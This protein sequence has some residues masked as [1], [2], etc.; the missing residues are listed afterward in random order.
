MEWVQTQVPGGQVKYYIDRGNETE[1][2]KALAEMIEQQPG[3]TIPTQWLETAA[4]LK[5][6][7][8]LKMVFSRKVHTVAPAKPVAVEPMPV[9][10]LSAQVLPAKVAAQEKPEKSAVFQE[11]V[12]VIRREIQASAEK[13]VIRLNTLDSTLRQTLT[14]VSHSDSFSC[15]E[16]FPCLMVRHGKLLQTA[17]EDASDEVQTLLRLADCRFQ[18]EAIQQKLAV[19]IRQ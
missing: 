8:L 18:I 17:G 13:L 16:C 11:R 3:T 12:L 2:M 5:M 10:I 9:Q 4:S 6:N 15:G 19:L 14:N 1:A 7:L